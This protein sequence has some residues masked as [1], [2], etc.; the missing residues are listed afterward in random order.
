METTPP[1][2]ADDVGI[3]IAEDEKA[4]SPSTAEDEK[5]Q[6]PATA[7]KDDEAQSPAPVSSCPP[8]HTLMQHPSGKIYAVPDGHSV[9]QREDGEVYFVPTQQQSPLP[10]T[11]DTPQQPQPMMVPQQPQQQPLHRQQEQPQ[12]QPPVMVTVKSVEAPALATDIDLSPPYDPNWTDWKRL[13]K[14]GSWDME[15]GHWEEPALETDGQV[16]PY[17]E[18]FLYYMVVRHILLQC[19]FVKKGDSYDRKERIAGL[20]VSLLNIWW[21]SV[22]I[23]AGEDS[24]WVID[25]IVVAVLT[26]PFAMIFELCSR[27]QCCGCEWGRFISIPLALMHLIIAIAL[28]IIF[29]SMTALFAFAGG[30]Y[31]SWFFLTPVGIAVRVWIYGRG[32][33]GKCCVRGYKWV[34][35]GKSMKGMGDSVVMEGT[36]LG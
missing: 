23:A 8:G 21:V 4:Q 24:N 2:V 25:A 36:G 1:L 28:S 20:A 26:A 7:K 35:I 5:A 3:A 14:P 22:I 10:M 12:P 34:G 30:L 15:L 9:M 17:L 18:R 19:L 33:E 32:A 16:A 27:A 31:F 11:M 29:S 6:S 13:F